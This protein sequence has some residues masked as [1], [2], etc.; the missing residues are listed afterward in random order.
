MIR[1]PNGART[2][3]EE[4]KGRFAFPYGDFD[5]VVRSALVHGEQRASQNDHEAV[6]EAFDD[7]LERLDAEHEG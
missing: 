4:T 1:S 2:A 5:E 3:S 7:L 6:R